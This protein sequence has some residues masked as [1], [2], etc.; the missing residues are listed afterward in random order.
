M[1]GI[2]VCE[3]L[4]PG[5]RR[6]VITIIALLNVNLLFC[7]NPVDVDLSCP[8]VGFFFP[9]HFLAFENTILCIGRNADPGVADLKSQPNALSLLLNGV[10]RNDDKALLRE[11]DLVGARLFRPEE[12]RRR[13]SGRARIN[14][15]AASLS[16]RADDLKHQPRRLALGSEWRK[17]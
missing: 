2:L 13:S 4:F 14:A 10:D 6:A 16:K 17:N 9:C 5:L 11:L 15:A 8:P 12:T 3:G 1:V 7:L